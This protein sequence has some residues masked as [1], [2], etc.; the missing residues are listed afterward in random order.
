MKLLF[1]MT[2]WDVFKLDLEPRTCKCG[3]VTGHYLANEHDAVTNGKGISLAIGNGSLQAAIGSMLADTK[4]PGGTGE[5]IDQYTY[6]RVVGKIENAWVRPNEGPR[7]PR[8]KVVKD[9]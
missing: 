1:C 8:Q 2:C 9:D 4:Y 5:D 7:N 3:L 6:Q